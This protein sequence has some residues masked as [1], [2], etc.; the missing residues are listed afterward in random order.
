LPVP[1]GGGFQDNDAP[2]K[3]E[4]APEH[5][6]WGRDGGGAAK[7]VLGLSAASLR[8]GDKERSPPGDM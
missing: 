8:I 6:E 3:L 4:V 2:E 5:E 7:V 1:G